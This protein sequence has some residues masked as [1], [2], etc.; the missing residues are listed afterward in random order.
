M[1]YAFTAEDGKKFT[2][3]DGALTH[4]INGDITDKPVAKTNQLKSVASKVIKGGVHT[5]QGITDFLQH[6]P[7][8]THLIDFDAKVHKAW[9]YAREL[10]NGVITL[11]IPKELF[12]NR[13]AKMTMYPDD[14]YKSGYLWK[15]LFPASFGE[16]EIIESIREALNNIDYEESQDGMVVGYACTDEILKTIRLTVQHKN[17]QINSAF[18]SWTQPNTGNNG[19]SYSH[20]DSIGHVISWSTVRLSTDMQG[21]EL[22]ETSNNKQLSVFNLLEITP[23]LF[24]ERSIPKKNNLEWQKKRK[25][26]LE[27]LSLAMDDSGIKSILD[28]TCNTCIIKNHNQITNLF[29]NEKS[30][31]LHSSIYFN[32]IQIHQ[33]ICDGLYVTSLL[34]NINSTNHLNYVIECLLKNMVSFVGIDSWCK[35]KIIHEIIHA[36]LIHHDKKI[37]SQFII[38]FSES[39]VRRELFIDFNLDSIVK[40]TISV[41]QIEMPFELTTVYG[42]NYNFDLKPEHFC[43]FIKENLGETYSLHFND[44]QREKIYNGFSESGGPNYNLMLCDVLKYITNDYFNLFQQVLSEI[45][46][47]LKIDDGVDVNKLDIAL[48]SIVR[49]YCRIQFAH[50]ARINLTYKEFNGIEL[51][52]IITDKNQ[53]YG[54]IL[55]HE[56][57]LNSHKL[58]MFLDELEDIAKKI[59]AKELPKQI[60]YFRSKIGKEV[61]PIISPIPQRIIDKNPSLQALTKGEMNAIWS[62]D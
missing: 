21:V 3:S 15:T 33:N 61:P 24:L 49:D 4:I 29:Y 44:M 2:L 23:R 52:L 20:Y 53:V 36:C 1:T 7:K 22:H 11:R 13:A 40:K 35:R 58:N 48:S 34:D 27:L 54:S 50:R 56:R 57:I 47:N 45:L 12:A 17:G 26:E 38:L 19:K 18:P 25:I 28:Y 30:F 10:Q 32:A 60:S 14:Y 43:E 51:P 5:V 37:I 9:Y 46:D 55:K 8:I 39:P 16:S 6:H 31:L 42:L 62:G 59:D 41:P